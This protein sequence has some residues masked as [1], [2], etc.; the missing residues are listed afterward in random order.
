[1][2]KNKFA[3]YFRGVSILAGLF[4]T[5]FASADTRDFQDSS[6]TEEMGYL[7]IL[8]GG[9]GANQVQENITPTLGVTL[10]AKIKPWLGVGL[11]G[12][13]FGQKSSGSLFGLETGTQ[14][15]TLVLTGQ[16]N[17]FAGGF[18]AGAEIGPAFSSWSGKISRL[19]SGDSTVA[20]VWGP[21]A[22]YDFAIGRSVSLGAEGHYLISTV[23][24]S[25]N[26][27][28]LFAALKLIL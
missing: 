1:M 28:Q 11:F 16:A 8:A 21:E 17:I 27:V 10:G 15:H 23:E 9:N 2:F 4:V 5:S 14:T 26:N 19:N 3:S 25:A 13:Y 24:G 6:S 18:H 22:G 20:M 12:S 7:G